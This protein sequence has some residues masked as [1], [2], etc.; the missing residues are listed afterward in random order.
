MKIEIKTYMQI[1]AKFKFK[2]THNTN[3][4]KVQLDIN[5][6]FSSEN[7]IQTKIL[8]FH[9]HNSKKNI[10]RMIL[11]CFWDTLYVHK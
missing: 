10:I 2:F 6:S 7:K 4:L 9:F 5:N 3:D 8:I 11:T 1:I